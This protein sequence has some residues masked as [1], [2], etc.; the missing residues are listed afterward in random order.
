VV[1]VSLKIF[2]AEKL[3]ELYDLAKAGWITPV[4]LALAKL[5]TLLYLAPVVTGVMTIRNAVHR[6]KHRA[7][8]YLVLGMTVLTAGTGSW[9]IL[10]AEKL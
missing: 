1:A 5:T 2:Y 4:H 3:G 6:P 8:A 9:M 7:A 10:A